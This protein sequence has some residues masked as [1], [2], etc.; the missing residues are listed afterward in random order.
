MPNDGIEPGLGGHVHE[1]PAEAVV[2]EHQEHLLANVA[3]VLQ[4]R[5]VKVLQ[6]ES[7][8]GGDDSNEEVGAGES[9]EGRRRDGEEET[10]ISK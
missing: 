5:I 9:Y 2:G 6:D 1:A 3:N 4:L 7:G 10:A 8:N